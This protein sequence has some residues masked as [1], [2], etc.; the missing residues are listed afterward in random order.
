MSEKT[1]KPTPKRL[2]DARK[3]G[4]VA[5]SK[6]I[7]TCAVIVGLFGYLWMFFDAYLERLKHLIVVPAQYYHLPFGQALIRCAKTGFQ[8]FALLSLPFILAAGTIVVLANMMQIGF[9]V[10]FE[11]ISPDIKKI[12]PME[13]I[14]KIFSLS[15]LVELLK[16]IAK[17]VMLGAI[18]YIVITGRVQDLLNMIHG[19]KEEIPVMLGATLKR[20]VLWVS[21]LFIVVAILDHFLQ[22]YLHI[23]KLK[24]SKDEIKREHKDREGDPHLKGRRRQLQM[25]MASDDMAMKIRESTIILTQS[26]ELAVAVY[27]EMGKTMLPIITVKGK[28]RVAEKVIEM[29]KKHNIPVYED[30]ALTRNL[31]KKIEQDNYISSDFIQPVAEK[32]RKAMGL[33]E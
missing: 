8:D 22:K 26:K 7:V 13:G 16:S 11:P 28:S 23:K 3:K 10:S 31:Y 33:E 4:Q 1:E 21:A 17:I 2:Q 30:P 29:A 6:E 5:K 19:T 20:M 32:L 14:K 12:N 25:E 15:N 9:M 18:V 27:Y 24:M